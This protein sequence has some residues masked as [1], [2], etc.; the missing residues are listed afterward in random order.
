M[1]KRILIVLTLLV[2]IYGTAFG[3]E[4]I[5]TYET[6]TGKQKTTDSADS[7]IT[8]YIELRCIDAGTDITIGTNKWGDF[9]VPV[10]M[11]VLG[12][13]AYVD[14]A[15]T[16]ANLLTVDI[17]EAGTTIISTK[18][19]LD[20]GEKTSETAATPPVIS[21]SSIAADAIITVDVDQIGNTTAGKGLVV[22]LKV[23]Y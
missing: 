11:T 18:I 13:G 15:A 2:F 5:V 20:S 22:W 23:K 10:A 14:T 6:T 8:R 12:V 7:Y 9:R 3:A 4:R 19:T 16:G 21:D 17:N 1:L